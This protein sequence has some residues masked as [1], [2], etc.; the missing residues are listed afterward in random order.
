MVSSSTNTSQLKLNWHLWNR[1]HRKK[2]IT[3]VHLWIKPI[4]VQSIAGQIL[5][6][7]AVL[8]FSY[9]LLEL[10]TVGTS[11]HILA[12]ISLSG[13]ILYVVLCQ[14]LRSI[15]TSISHVFTICCLLCLIFFPQVFCL[16]CRTELWH[17]NE[18]HSLRLRGLF[19]KRWF[20][21][22]VMLVFL[23]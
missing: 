20:W 19:N 4:E 10:F 16:K 5:C 8:C 23:S 3:L 9:L 17:W 1:R 22:K 6:T 15:W 7:P 18:P 13:S 2:P 12:Q 14:A 21:R 11:N